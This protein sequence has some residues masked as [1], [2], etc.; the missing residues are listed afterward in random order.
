M[1]LILSNIGCYENK[2][3]E[4][5]KGPTLISGPS[6]RG[7]TTIARALMFVLFGDGKGLKRHSTKKCSVELFYKDLHIIRT[8]GPERI[9]VWYADDTILVE[10]KQAQ[11]YLDERFPN[12]NI[13]LS[14]TSKNFIHETPL[15]K[16][17]F[18]EKMA[19]QGILPSSLKDKLKDLQK[20]FN[21]S[22]KEKE[23]RI[24]M[25]DSFL[26]Q[27]EEIV[28]VVLPEDIE[29]RDY[30]NT[31]KMECKEYLKILEEYLFDENSLK[32]TISLLQT[33]L[34]KLVQEKHS[35]QSSSS[36]LEDKKY[37]IDQLSIISRQIK[38][39]HL[40]TQIKS[41]CQNE[42][43]REI[44][45]E[46]QDLMNLD[47]DENSLSEKVS[48][49]RKMVRYI[50]ER[51]DIQRQI[52]SMPEENDNIITE[53][54]NSQNKKNC[55]EKAIK[56]LQD[57]QNCPHC[58]KAILV[59][60][61]KVFSCDGRKEIETEYGIFT[62]RG[63]SKELQK[64]IKETVELKQQSD[65]EVE[66]A[67]LYNILSLKLEKLEPFI[68]MS[69]EEAK[70]EYLECN[71]RYK[72]C[73]T[74]ISR[75]ET[76]EMQRINLQ[77]LQEKNSKKI[78]SLESQ[79]EKTEEDEEEKDV[80]ALQTKKDQLSSSLSS[81]EYIENSLKRIED[82]IQTNRE[83][84]ESIQRKFE[85]KY[86]SFVFDQ[87]S[88][89]TK[90]EIEEC[91]QCLILLDKYDQYIIEYNKKKSL[92]N[93]KQEYQDDIKVLQQKIKSSSI[94]KELI[95]KAETVALEN[96][97]YTV[98]NLLETPLSRFFE[99]DPIQISLSTHKHISSSNSFRREINLNIQFKGMDGIDIGSLSKGEQDRIALVFTLIFAEMEHNP[100]LILDEC[101][102][103]LD[104]G[105]TENIFEYIIE[106]FKEK[107]LIVIAHQIVNGVFENIIEL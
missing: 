68:T 107:W 29:T 30:Y 32:T 12:R 86:S 79:I 50:N 100:F 98:N 4:F 1:K 72:N 26:K 15:N 10:N 35:I 88:Q 82:D 59:V 94:L 16:L 22:Y 96:F 25:I 67:S 77:T 5:S 6:G 102:S 65:Q 37:I 41:L 93:E 18:I 62:K 76:F 46:I 78:K 52:E 106:Y 42:K 43:I 20:N 14:Q 17:E 60:N 51:D 31:R 56:S 39:I 9:K 69:L 40:E 83:R 27:Q 74:N 90:K 2:V 95:S 24:D 34:K 91:E 7:K 28:N 21:V 104:S 97:V 73:L 36:S 80:Y 103:N 89:E 44:E 38:N 23:T 81:I 54:Q 49:Y 92:E 58:E 99:D 61:D 57:F 55:L 85:E 3:F 70:K 84:Q 47:L 66:C 63:L 8:K 19:F 105:N 75:M 13:F 53:Y 101:T 87:S 45:K 64:C 71:N 33:E 11:L 48:K